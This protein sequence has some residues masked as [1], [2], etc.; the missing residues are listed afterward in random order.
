MNSTYPYTASQSTC[1]FNPTR[2]AAKVASWTELNQNDCQGLV[3][4]VNQKPVAVAI[5]ANTMQLYKSGV[6]TDTTC[7]TNLNHGVVVVGYGYDSVAQ[8]NFWI[9]RNSW[10]SSWG[11]QGYIRMF[12]DPAVTNGA[13]QC[14]ICIAAST[15]NV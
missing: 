8:K 2:I 13:G 9:V 15:V 7:T 14:G 11:E 1:R 3:N 6:F 10:G 12:R 5:D 4:L